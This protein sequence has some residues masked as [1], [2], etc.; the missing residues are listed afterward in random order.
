[1]LYTRG[2]AVFGFYIYRFFF[3]FAVCDFQ[4]SPSAQCPVSKQPCMGPRFHQ[5]NEGAPP[6]GSSCSLGSLLPIPAQPTP[7]ADPSSTAGRCSRRSVPGEKTVSKMNKNRLCYTV[8]TNSN[9]GKNSFIFL[10]LHSV[11]L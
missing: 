9:K 7:L 5:C 2:R 11:G 8:S 6:S 10:R 3:L 4:K 1:M